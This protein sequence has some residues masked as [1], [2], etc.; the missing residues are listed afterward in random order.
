MAQSRTVSVDSRKLRLRPKVDILEHPIFDLSLSCFVP[1]G[2][3]FYE[4]CQLLRS[5][6]EVEVSNLPV[7]RGQ[8]MQE[9]VARYNDSGPTFFHVLCIYEGALA[10]GTRTGAATEYEFFL[11][12]QLC[13]FGVVILQPTVGFCLT[14]DGK[15]FMLRVRYEELRKKSSQ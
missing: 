8:Q 4:M 3:S 1:C 15:E 12:D 13:R 6:K 10:I 11:M 2:L 9:C 5:E 14:D 7:P